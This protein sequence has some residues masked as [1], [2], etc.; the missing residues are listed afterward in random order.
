MK[1][2]ILILMFATIPAVC[3]TFGEPKTV[4]IAPMIGN[5]DGFIAAEIFKQHA[6][7]TVT[8]DETHAEMILTGLSLRED[9]HWYNVAFNRG[10]DK[11]E[12]NL[13]LID[14]KSKTVIW[15]GEAGDRQLFFSG[16]QRGGERKVAQ[17]L[18]GVYFEH[19]GTKN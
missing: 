7:L 19:S 11:N 14:V 2:T 16:W 10:K 17:R 13:Q 3:Q 9:D 8:T 18:A 4:Y 6:P 5:L 15:S 12:G 1:N